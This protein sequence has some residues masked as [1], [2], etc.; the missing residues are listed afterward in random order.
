MASRIRQA[1]RAVGIT[2]SQVADRLNVSRSAVAQWERS[3]GSN[4]VASNLEKLAVELACSFEWLA[5]GRGSRSAVGKHP[6]PAEATAVVLR[7]FA[8]DDTEE[9]LL[10]TF[11]E[12]DLWDQRLLMSM[13]ET[14]SRRP[15][16]SRRKSKNAPVG[17]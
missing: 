7:H 3:D 2:Q 11:R 16:A 9:L 14:L 8:R 17:S 5:T 6:A 13:A 4:P 12:L 1:R 15:V 10:D